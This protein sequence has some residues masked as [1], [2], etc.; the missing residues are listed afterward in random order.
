MT[1]SAPS[2]T[3]FTEHSAPAVLAE[4]TV[5]SIEVSRPTEGTKVVTAPAAVA[6]AGV[7][8]SALQK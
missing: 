1:I 2:C 8:Q 4:W 6:E 7:S 3:G 5:A